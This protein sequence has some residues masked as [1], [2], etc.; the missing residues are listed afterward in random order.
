MIVHRQGDWV[1]AKI[2]EEAVMMSVLRKTNI[3]LNE[4]GVQIWD[5]TE[6]PRSVEEICDRLIERYDVTRETC[7]A[8]VERFLG[9]MRE[10]GVV[11]FDLTQ[12]VQQ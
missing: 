7:R 8:E 2:G 1:V 12:S 3:G 6:I 4:V 5:A 9:Q 11:E 10:Q